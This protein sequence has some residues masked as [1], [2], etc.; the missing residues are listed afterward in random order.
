M[1]L[2]SGIVGSHFWEEED[3]AR[4]KQEVRPLSLSHTQTHVRACMFQMRCVKHLENGVIMEQKIEP[5]GGGQK[6]R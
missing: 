6:G 4:A 5:G 2:T 3:Q 1:A